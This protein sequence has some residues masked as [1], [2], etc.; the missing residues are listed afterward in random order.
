MLVGEQEKIEI[1]VGFDE[2]VD[3]EESVVGRDVVVH[4]AVGEEEMALQIF[5][6]GLVGLGVVVRGAIGIFYQQA[7]VAFAPVIFVLAIIVVA[8]FGD[9][10][11][12]EIRVAKHGVGRGITAAGVAV[13]SGTVDID[14]GILRGQLFHPSDLIGKGVVFHF[15]GV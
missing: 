11:L 5:R 9:S 12:K 15:G 3:D 2:G 6:Q 4:G 13:D 10:H 7:H 1:L 8:G 14:P